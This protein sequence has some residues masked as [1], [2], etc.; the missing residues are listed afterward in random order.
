MLNVGD[1]APDFS[2]TTQQ[3]QTFSLSALRGKRAVLFFFPKA[4]STGCT[5]QTANA[6]PALIGALSIRKEVLRRP[7][8]AGQIKDCLI[9]V[10]LAIHLSQGRRRPD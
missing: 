7:A 1:L 3:G 2:A 9:G 4:M 8:V 5:I 6:T 10:V